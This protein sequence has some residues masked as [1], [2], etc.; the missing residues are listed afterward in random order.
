MSNGPE[1]PDS[2]VTFELM[3]LSRWKYA[4]SIREV[5]TPFE[6]YMQLHMRQHR[7]M[8]TS[9]ASAIAEDIVNWA[10]QFSGMYWGSRDVPA[11]GLGGVVAG[12]TPTLDQVYPSH[13]A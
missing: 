1:G 10:T 5:T 4:Q 2:D 8:D 11:S 9:F 13:S 7:L 6:P 12:L 3:G